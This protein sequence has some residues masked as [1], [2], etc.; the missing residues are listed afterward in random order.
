MT[1][2]THPPFLPR[3]RTRNLPIHT[4]AGSRLPESREP[5]RGTRAPACQR[6]KLRKKIRK[7]IFGHRVE[8]VGIPGRSYITRYRL[9]LEVKTVATEIRIHADDAGKYQVPPELKGDV[10]YGESIKAVAAFLYSERVVSSGRICTFI[11]SLSGDSLDISEGS[12]Y[13]FCSSFSSKCT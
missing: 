11:N 10:T 9:D 2:P 5:R 8:E 1:A 13:N 3:M 7:G 6:R 12:I 4:T